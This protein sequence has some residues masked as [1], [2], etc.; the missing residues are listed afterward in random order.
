MTRLI[1]V[2]I[3]VF[4]IAQNTYAGWVQ[5]GGSLNHRE[6]DHSASPSIAINNNQIYVAFHEEFDILVRKFN[7]TSWETIGTTLNVNT[8]DNAFNPRV[9]SRFEV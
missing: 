4:L 8:N 5:D 3:A 6:A 1:T 2:I 9:M 7:G